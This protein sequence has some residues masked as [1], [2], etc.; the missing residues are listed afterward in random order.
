ME[1]AI[2]TF[3]H[4]GERFGV[5]NFPTVTV[6]LELINGSRPDLVQLDATPDY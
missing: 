4:L 6:P 1:K 2:W 3:N 5:I